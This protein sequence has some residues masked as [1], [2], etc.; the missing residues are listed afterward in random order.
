MNYQKRNCE[1]NPFTSASKRKKYLGTNF[2]NEAKDWHA[3]N[4][5]ERN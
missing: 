1:N 4:N 2:S 5:D 3:E